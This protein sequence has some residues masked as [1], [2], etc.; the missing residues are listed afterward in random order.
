MAHQNL[1][2]NYFNPNLVYNEKD[3]RRRFSMRRHVFERVLHDVQH[4]NPYFRQKMDRAGRLGFSSHQKVNFVLRMLAYDTPANAMDDIYGM[5]ESTC[6]D[7][8]AEF[9]ETIVQLYKEEYNRQPNQ[10]DLNRF[11]CKDED[12]GFLGMIGTLDCMPWQWKKCP[13]G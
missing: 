3:F 4:V 10:V 11:P 8:L 13:I 2:N 6:L 9:C 7:T 1:M 12:R 5:S